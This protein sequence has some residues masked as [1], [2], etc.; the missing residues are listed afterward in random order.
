MRGQVLPICISGYAVCD[1]RPRLISVEPVQATDVCPRV[2]QAFRL[3]VEGDPWYETS[4]ASDLHIAPREGCLNRRC[5][6]SEELQGSKILHLQRS[7]RHVDTRR[8][9]ESVAYCASY[10]TSSIRAGRMDMFIGPISDQYLSTS[11][12]LRNQGT[13]SSRLAEMAEPQHHVTRS[14]HPKGGLWWHWQGRDEPGTRNETFLVG[15]MRI[16]HK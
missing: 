12:A 7:W 13:N 11:Q 15:N 2:G 4:S 6:H 14:R 10:G 3:G 16:S 5:Y 8:E 1:G 9:N